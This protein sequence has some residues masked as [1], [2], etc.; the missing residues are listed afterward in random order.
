MA[1][2]AGVAMA[3]PAAVAGPM[4]SF[5]KAWTHFASVSQ[6]V[7]QASV[8][9]ESAAEIVAHDAASNRVFV[10]N[11]EQGRVDVLNASNG[12]FL[13]SLDVSN[14][15][16]P[17]SVAV[18][19]GVVAV[20][21]ENAASPQANGFLV[22]FD[23]ADAAVATGGI[24]TGNVEVGALPDMVAF[25]PDGSKAIVANE[26]EPDFYG[27][28][29]TDPEGSISIVDV[30]SKT[31]AG[32]ADFS[33]FT[34]AALVAAGV[35]IT[36]PG[37]GGATESTAAEDIEPE[38]ITVSA[39]GK[40]AYV[41][42]QENNAIAV[43]DI[44]SAT[45]TA[46][47][48]LQL[49]DH[50]AAGNGIDASDRDGG[51]NIQQWDNVKGMP[52]PDSI[53]SYE[54]DG[55]TYL[56]TANEGDGREYDEVPAGATGTVYSDEI[57]FKDL[58]LGGAVTAALKADEE[59]G[60]LTVSSVALDGSTP[61][62]YDEVMS[63]GTRSFSIWD[64]D[65]GDLVWDSGDFFEQFTAGLALADQ[66]G[67]PVFNSDNDGND[68]FDSRSDAKGPEPEAL[69]IGQI[70]DHTLAFVGL[71]RIGGIMV[72]DISNPASPIFL[73]YLLDRDFTVAADTLAAGDLGPEGLYFVRPEDSPFG[74][75]GLVVASEVSG[76]TS[77]YNI[78]L[79]PLPAPLA[80]FAAG[81]PLLL[82][83][84]RRR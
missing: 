62:T 67:N 3:A 15:G 54:V 20:A 6:G 75:Y 4:I 73:D 40:T 8:F 2:A 28:D 13:G 55:K 16:G 38:Y 34:K 18:K 82:L 59:L 84:R 33:A 79:V 23:A 76:S 66:D 52:M 27:Q 11:G 31:L 45:V 25:T 24:A 60:R 30:A 63:F 12:A 50:G 46:V 44:D 48:G 64:A 69:V 80:L 9:D 37:I 71:E 21:V 68:S 32:T 81:L 36:G 42:L 77:W 43:V 14:F 5:D 22:F 29:G 83:A 78:Q 41:S 47:R 57:R 39:D 19:N 58:P 10:V 70:F 51:I 1:V 65:S 26:G 72:F 74:M 35:R 61:T 56:V 53:G 7:S 49:K 17:N